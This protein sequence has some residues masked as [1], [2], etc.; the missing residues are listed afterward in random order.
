MLLAVFKNFRK[1]VNLEIIKKYKNCK[2]VKI[3]ILIREIL[4]F[5]K[6]KNISKLGFISF[7]K[8]SHIIS[9]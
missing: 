8:K 5:I 4:K 9:K 2:I 6:I 1:F 7:K 3:N